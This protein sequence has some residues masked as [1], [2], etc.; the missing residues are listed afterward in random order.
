M[1]W[2]VAPQPKAGG[3]Q[4][5]TVGALEFGCGHW[6]CS[7]VALLSGCSKSLAAGVFKGGDSLTNPGPPK[8]TVSGTRLEILWLDIAILKIGLNR[9]FVAFLRTTLV[10]FVSRQLSI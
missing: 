8:Q 3:A 1:Y 2:E 6:R 9:V 4:S 7:L 10:S 5:G